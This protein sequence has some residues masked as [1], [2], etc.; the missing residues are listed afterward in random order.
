MGDPFSPMGSGMLDFSAYEK[1]T[2]GWI[3]AQPHADTAGDFRLAVP[4]LRTT[5]P[6]ALIINTPAGRYWIEYRAQPFR[7]LLVRF[8]AWQNTSTF[9][10]QSILILNPTRARRPWIAAG[11]TYQI[12]GSFRATLLHAGTIQANIRL[13]R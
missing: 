10:A 9:A 2:L 8:V 1:A 6:Q 13:H 12:P 4:T 5:L 3:P 7:G 11:E